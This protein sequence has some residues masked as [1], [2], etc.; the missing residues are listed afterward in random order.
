MLAVGAGI[1]LLL[2]Y[3]SL[4]F[5]RKYRWKD[6]PTYA[7]SN[8]RSPFPHLCTKKLSHTCCTCSRGGSL[9]LPHPIQP[10]SLSPLI[11]ASNS[12]SP[13]PHLCTKRLSRTCCTCSRGGS[14]FLPNPIQPHSLSPLIMVRLKM[15]S[16][17]TF[18]SNMIKNTI[19]R[20]VDCNAVSWF[21][22]CK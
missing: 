16:L 11:M 21:S 22:I 7:A 17:D 15:T 5:G 10:H 18:Q 2:L 1:F 3:W 12:R 8:S 13:F 6:S 9:F 20:Y 19:K 14:L 4:L